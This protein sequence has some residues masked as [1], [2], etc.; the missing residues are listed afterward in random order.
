MGTWGAK[1]FKR[2]TTPRHMALADKLLEGK[3][4]KDA[5]IEV[6]YSPASASNGSSGIPKTVWKL[7]GKKSPLLDLGGLEPSTRAKLI[8]GRL[9]HG[10]ITGSDKGVQAAYRAGQDRELNM[11]TPDSQVGVIVINTP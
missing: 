4:I 5:M 10:V 8:R 6:G 1:T 2:R 9:M 11:F 3:T 7:M